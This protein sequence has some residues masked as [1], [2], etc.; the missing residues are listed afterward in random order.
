MPPIH[1][2]QVVAGSSRRYT[3]DLAAR[4]PDDRNGG[5]NGA[6]PIIVERAQYRDV[7]A[8]ARN[9]I[10]AIKEA[11]DPLENYMTDT[12]DRSEGKW[13]DHVEFIIQCC[14]WTS[15]PPP[16]DQAGSPLDKIFNGFIGIINHATWSKQQTKRRAEFSDK[17][18]KAIR[19]SFGDR[20]KD[21]FYI[22]SVATA[23]AKQRRG[24]ASM[25]MRM[26]CAMADEINCATWLVVGNVRMN[27]AF[28]VRFGF[29]TVARILLGEDDPDWTEEPVPVDVMI[30]EA[31]SSAWN[32]KTAM[33]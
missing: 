24:Y 28:Y 16:G 5:C 21:M 2:R 3:T 15:H 25:L 11:H 26:A 29:V 17:L 31:P 14:W 1:T 7:P 22:T 9:A 18:R 23:P 33:V 19:S 32:E 12:P 13:K 10:Q 27:N 20:L 6:E 8:M 4:K 30:R